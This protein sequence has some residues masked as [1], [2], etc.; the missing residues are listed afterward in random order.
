MKFEVGQLWKQR[1]GKVVR[2]EHIGNDYG[3]PIKMND[4]TSRNG[5]GYYWGNTNKDE[6]DLIVLVES[7]ESSD[8]NEQDTTKSL[9]KN[10]KIML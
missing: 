8:N 2:I 4:S 10:I 6:R 9:K 3:Y 7:P 1:D 5:L